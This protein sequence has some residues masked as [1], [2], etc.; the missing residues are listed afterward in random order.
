MEPPPERF[1]GLGDNWRPEHWPVPVHF[2]EPHV[3]SSGYFLAAWDLAG[4]YLETDEEIVPVRG[5]PFRATLPLLFEALVDRND[6]PYCQVRVGMRPTGPACLRLVVL[7]RPGEKAL[8][9]ERVRVPL[10]GLVREVATI[11]GGDGIMEA[12]PAPVEPGKRIPDEHFERVA[13]VYRYAVKLGR[14]PTE[15]V[16]EAF[17]VA[18]STAGRWVVQ[19]RRR[20]FLGPAMPGRAGEKPLD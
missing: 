4:H 8:T 3:A 6:L 1:P 14:P 11:I 9:T 16:A 10:D 13:D 15:G 17:D 7:L 20:G 12:Y 5:E 19:A 18:R 2:E